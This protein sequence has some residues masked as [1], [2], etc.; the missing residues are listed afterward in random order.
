MA[1]DER[2]DEDGAQRL[3]RL[4]AEFAD[5]VAEG[6]GGDAADLLAQAL[7]A[8]RDELQRLFDVIAWGDAPPRE[9]AAPLIAGTVLGGCR[10]VAELGRGGMAAVWRAE[11]LELRRTVALKLLRPGLSLDPRHAARFRREALA[12]AR[13]DHPHVVKIH[14]VGAERGHLFLVMEFVEGGTLAQRLA[15]QPPP[16]NC[17]AE[18]ELARLFAPA[19][20]ALHAAHERGVVHRDV[21]PSNLL[22]RRDGSLV[23]A[24]F[25]LAKGDGDL[26]QTL[27]GEPLG[28]PY[29]M[30]PEQVE[31]QR[32]A[33]DARTDVY[34]LG[35]ALYEALSGKRPFEGRTTIAL[36]DAIRHQQAPPLRARNAACSAAAEAVVAKAMARAREERYATAADFAAD[37]EALAEG[38]PVAAM[39]GSGFSRGFA[40]FVAARQRGEPFDHRSTRAWRGVPLLHVSFGAPRKPATARGWIALGDRA[41]GL[42]AIGNVAR[43]VVAIGNFA[44]GLFAFGGLAAGGFA[45]GGLAAGGV[46]MGGVAA[47]GFALGGCA[48]GAVAI[49][50]KAIGWY[51][52]GGSVTA[53]EAISPQ[54]CSAKAAALFAP[55]ADRIG[56]IAPWARDAIERANR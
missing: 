33:V 46:A 39:A 21:K 17:A 56:A 23:V 10:L 54:E 31:Q 41:V 14:A 4:V 42:V 22:L 27:T 2:A 16:A 30:S 1:R 49:G 13:L 38:R 9:P 45:L 5:R 15:T 34:S 40:R 26:A 11:Q 18:R 19:A 8:E 25:G 24:D 20:R 32:A 48:L 47:G 7:P 44:L 35:V 51:A 29:Y 43:G 52:L 12:I 36:F 55:W 53:V 50:G 28:T 3:D 37:L 6:R